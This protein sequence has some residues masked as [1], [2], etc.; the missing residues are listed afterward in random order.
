MDEVHEVAC[1]IL[2]KFEELLERKGIKIP[3]EDRDGEQDEACLFGSE[4]RELEDAI[5]LI[6][7]EGVEVW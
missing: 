5:L 7:N 6:L 1:R 4:Y 3:S 2:G